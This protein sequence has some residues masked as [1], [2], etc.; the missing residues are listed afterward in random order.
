MIEAKLASDMAWGGGELDR[1]LF[2]WGE[3]PAR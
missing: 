2:L 1:R 3:L